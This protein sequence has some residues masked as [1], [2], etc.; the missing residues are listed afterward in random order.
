MTFSSEAI[1]HLSG[2]WRTGGWA[3]QLHAHARETDW[4]CRRE[5]PPTCQQ[6]PATKD[7]TEAQGRGALHSHILGGRHF[8]CAL[9]D[10]RPVFATSYN[11]E[12]GCSKKTSASLVRE[13]GRTEGL[14]RA[15]RNSAYSSRERQ[16]SAPEQTRGTSAAIRC[17]SGGQPVSPQQ[18]VPTCM[19]R[20]HVHCL[21]N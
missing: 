12:E 7:R 11:R 14:R 10:R 2:T 18:G 21:R 19:Y 6:A 9:L 1:L 17:I 20:A 8:L 13:E 16:S 3:T 15:A 4:V 5:H